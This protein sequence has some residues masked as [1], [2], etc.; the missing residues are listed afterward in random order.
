MIKSMLYVVAIIVVGLA[1]TSVFLIWRGGSFSQKTAFLKIGDREFKVEIADTNISRIRGL[2]GRD[3]LG[4]NEGML[5][6]WDSA[7]RYPF[8]M[9]GM[10][11]PL[12]FVWIREG[13]VV[14][15]TENVSH[16][17]SSVFSLPLY[18]PPEEVNMV[19]EVAS[20]TVFSAGIKKGDKVE[21]E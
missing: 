16:A 13:E 20:G 14:G 1:V 2:S 19:L 15:V 9:K 10:K 8:W 4:K 12:D 11:F 18:Y 7:A 6:V 3:P 5:F 21:V 17:S